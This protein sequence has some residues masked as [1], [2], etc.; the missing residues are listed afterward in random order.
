MSKQIPEVTTI[1]LDLQTETL[2]SMFGDN[3]HFAAIR[4]KCGGNLLTVTDAIMQNADGSKKAPS[5]GVENLK[6]FFNSVAIVRNKIAQLERNG[7]VLAAHEAREAL[8]RPNYRM[9]GEIEPFEKTAPVTLVMFNPEYVFAALT[10]ELSLENDGDLISSNLPKELRLE[11][12]SEKSEWYYA[13]DVF[14]RLY[15]LSEP[16]IKHLFQTIPKEYITVEPP[17][18]SISLPYYSLQKKGS[19]KMPTNILT[20]AFCAPKEVILRC[21]SHKE[22]TKIALWEFE[23]PKTYIR[24]Q[25]HK[26]CFGLHKEAEHAHWC[27][28]RAPFCSTNISNG[29]GALAHPG[30]AFHCFDE[31]T[32]HFKDTRI[33]LY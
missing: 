28:T 27:K 10:A 23:L 8:K 26:L 22:H 17:R 16:L 14:H 6:D 13:Y 30:E 3:Q 2:I 31:R 12:Y 33:L 18:S 24:K 11:F 15:Q 5:H 1:D 7:L 25:A 9:L 19:R 21:F 20:F 4:G 29:Y 32:K